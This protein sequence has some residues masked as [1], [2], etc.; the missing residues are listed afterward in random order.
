MAT[1]QPPSGRP[2]RRLGTVR[3]RTTAAAVLVVG[4]ALL[5]GATALVM[6]LRSSLER[7]VEKAA[8]LRAQDVATALEGGT[9]PSGLALGDGDESFVQVVDERGEVVVASAKVRGLGPVADLQPGDGLTLPGLPGEEEDPFIVVATRATGPGEGFTVLVGRSLDPVEDSSA[10]VAK[11]LLFGV[12]L[13]LLVVALTTWGVVGRAL[14]FVE[15]IRTQVAEISASQLHRRVPDPPGDDEIARLAHTMNAML[16]RLEDEQQRQRRFVS[17][18]SHEL[19]SPVATIRNLTEVAIAHPGRTDLEEFSTAV[20]S[21][22]IRIE[23][24]VDD[25]LILARSDEGRTSLARRSVDL[26]DV[27][28]EE[29]KRLRGS[30]RLDIETGAVSGGRTMGDVSQLRRVVRNLADNAA[31]H[32]TSAITFSLSQENDW[33]VMRV[34]DDGPGIAAEN[35]EAIFQRFARLDNAR[36]RDHGGAGLGLAIVYESIR[37]HGGTIEVGDSPSGGARFEIRLP[38]QE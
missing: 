25:L 3:V 30:T 15:S 16:A 9:D 19:R 17:D 6:T 14:R 4:L 26:D 22:D 5:I 38:R 24:L 7:D 11:I 8:R 10:I 13:L 12:P 1:K 23:R 28:L 33:I 32:A 18:A 31:Q 21:E 27:V 20:L 35:R 37:A 36:D 34:E 29:A 2:W